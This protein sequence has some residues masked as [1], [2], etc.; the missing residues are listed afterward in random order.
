MF[1]IAKVRGESMTPALSPGDYIIFTKAR[2]LRPGFVVL[3]DHSKY[4]LIVKRISSV[5][6]DG[7]F[8]QG[9]GPESTSSEAMGLIPHERLRGRAR[10][11]ITS[12]G[13]TRL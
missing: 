4:G 8:L 9:D 11:A 12:K 6:T 1:K 7:V 3:V 13:L 2:A 10:L 5:Q